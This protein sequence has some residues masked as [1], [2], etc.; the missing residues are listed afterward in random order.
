M[1]KLKTISVRSLFLVCIIGLYGCAKTSEL[2]N[3]VDL[4]KKYDV[5]I[6]RDYLGVPHIIGNKD[7]DA[8]FGF[9][10]AQA[11]DNWAIIHDSIP[12]YR[13]TN[14]SINGED[15]AAID[16]LIKWLG[17]WETVDEKYESHLKPE[18][19][20]WIQAFVD[21]I[22]YYA[23]LHPEQTNEN[24]FPIT[25]KDVVAGY[26]LRHLLFFGFDG[27][28]MELFEDE[29]QRPVSRNPTSKTGESYLSSIA[30]VLINDLP[31]GSN[32]IAVSSPFTLDGATRLAI[33]SHQPT[34]G[35]VAWYEAHIQSHEGLNIMGGLFPSSATI[36]V[37][38]TNNLAWG[39]TVNKPDLVDIFVLETDPDNPMRYKLDGKWKNLTSKD[40]EI[41]VKLF[42]FFP[43]TVKETVFASDHGPVIQNDHGTYAV[44]Y[45]GMGEIRQLEQWLAM[46]KAQNFDQ[47][48]D[49]MRMQSF[50]SFNFVYADREGNTMFV[51][52]SLTPKRQS[53]Y[54]WTQYLPGD[55]GQLIWQDYMEFDDLPQVTNPASGYLHSA[56][57]TPFKVTAAADNP[58]KEDYKVEDG[59][60]TRMTNRANRGLELL[61]DMD[62]ISEHQFFELKHDKKYSINSRAYQFLKRAFDAD[63]SLSQI[64]NNPIYS[65][66]QALIADWDLSTDINSRG[67]ALGTC[68]LGSEWLS[69]QKGEVAPDPLG[70][71]IRCTDLLMDKVGRIDPLW[72]DINRHIRGD[73]NIP[74]GGGPDTL[75]AIYGMG[76]EDNG[77]LTNVA[78]DGLYYQ[79]SWDTD[80][81]LKVQGTHQFGS[82]TL[83][84]DSPHFGDQAQNYANE[85]LHD[86][87]FD[88]ALRQTKLERRYR[89]GE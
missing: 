78:G 55:D 41:K 31:I 66:A 84:V 10:Y 61:E 80:G 46:N 45:A 47:W 68:V 70:E 40:I 7:V 88:D 89:P 9:A 21:G 51:H 81:Q 18:T 37:G 48:L 73:I 69:E 50:A 67:A 44:R 2:N 38:F 57:Q 76:L 19:R 30:G 63:I 59:F 64:N 65:S 35:P 32:A 4:G 60:P 25:G 13:G 34:T 22:N 71:L 43:W 74:I 15:A 79:V 20:G 14:A 87:L 17:I 58:I 85:I 28:I 11:E 29:R 82:A 52:N 6:E 36:G 77:F 53:G 27:P 3:F 72:G 75:R 8:A 56:N 1:Y 83:D 24:I 86:P 26:M 16:F 5:V 42:G 12:F 49:A 39:A 23:A 54:D 62:S 33:N